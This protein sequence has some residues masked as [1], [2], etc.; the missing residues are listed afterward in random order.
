MR[1]FIKKST[2]FL[3][4]LITLLGLL[5]TGSVGAAEMVADDVYRLAA[6]E[7]I[8]DDLYVSAGEVVIDGTV[9]GDLIATGGYIEVNGLVTGDA[10]LAGAGIELNGEVQDDLRLAGSGLN[11]AGLIGDDL[12]AAGGGG[13]AFAMPF[14]VEGHTV[15]QGVRLTDQ[16]EVGADAY[17]IGGQGDLGGTING[18]L[19]SG[20]GRLNLSAEVGE[21]AR[22]YA[23]QI[24]INDAARVNGTLRYTTD[25]S[26]TIPEGIAGNVEYVEPA[27]NESEANPLGNFLGWWWRTVLTLVGFALVA[28]LTLRFAPRLLTRPVDAIATSPARS[29]LFGVL[30]AAV[31]IVIPLASILI[32]LLM[33]LFWGWIPGLVL[34]LVLFGALMLVWVLS[35]L[36]T[37]LWLGYWLNQRLDYAPDYLP[38][39]LGGVLGVALLGRIPVL[40]WAI[41]LISFLLAL[42]G[43]VLAR[44]TGSEG[45][46]YAAIANR[47]ASQSVS[48][49]A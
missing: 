34:G 1:K 25:E 35:P 13:S 33:I 7:V 49:T 9:E 6:D 10:M 20:M 4:M 26:Q 47:Q 12:F 19:N 3:L 11:I 22:L 2:W 29:G 15:D 36:V 5:L 44:Y 48:S 27:S 24:Q 46:L 14:P 45:P 17:V 39:L 16:A 28:W 30:A 43:L 32:I 23:D 40:G 31:L 18:V 41:Y 8:T 42:G 38:I 21:D 37:G